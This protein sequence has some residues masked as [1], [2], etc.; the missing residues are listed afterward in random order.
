MRCLLNCSIFSDGGCEGRA[1]CAAA[2]AAAAAP[3]DPRAGA[4]GDAAADEAGLYVCHSLAH[5]Q[6]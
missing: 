4:S 3:A 6:G 5:T 2:A 1:R